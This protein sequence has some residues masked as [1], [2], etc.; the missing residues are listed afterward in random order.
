[1]IEEVTKLITE[2]SKTKPLLPLQRMRH[3]EINLPN[4]KP[5]VVHVVYSV[6][7]PSQQSLSS[8]VFVV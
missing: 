1:M 4:G 6:V 5:T 8:F 2:H 7:L 3:R